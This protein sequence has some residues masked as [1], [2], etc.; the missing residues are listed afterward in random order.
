LLDLCLKVALN[1][2]FIELVVLFKID[3]N[4]CK[5]WHCDVDDV[6]DPNRKQETDKSKKCEVFV[7]VVH[8]MF[9][10]VLNSFHEEKGE[11]KDGEVE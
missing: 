6:Y 8:E 7:E 9:F 11:A 2:S 4:L 5:M 1:D 10:V 3:H